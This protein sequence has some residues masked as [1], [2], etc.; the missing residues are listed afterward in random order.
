MPAIVIG[1]HRHGHVTDFGF[2][3][4][5]GFLE[6]GHADDVHAPGAVHVRLGPGRERRPLHAEVRAAAVGV[7]S[8]GAAGLFEHVAQV[9]ADR[10]REG[11]VRD[12]A[13]AEEG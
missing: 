3:R 8:G 11:D 12:D 2:T 13:V 9:R 7:Y 4:Q 5:L 10:V 1:H 6:V